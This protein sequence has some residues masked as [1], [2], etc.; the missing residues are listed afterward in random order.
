MVTDVLNRIT[1]HFGPE[2][3]QSI[4][5]GVTLGAAQ[6]AEEMTLPWLRLTMK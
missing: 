1:T 2:T 3:I 5:D 4:L 6:R